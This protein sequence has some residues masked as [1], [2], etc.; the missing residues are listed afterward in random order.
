LDLALLIWILESSF[1]FG[2][3]TKE[4]FHFHFEFGK[5]IAELLAG[6][7]TYIRIS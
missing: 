3:E 7:Y 5:I 6:Y 4:A 2:F 1:G